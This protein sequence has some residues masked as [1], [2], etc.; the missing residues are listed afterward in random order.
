MAFS[1][2]RGA[3][4]ITRGA[5]LARGTSSAKHLILI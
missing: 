5:C 3:F 2:A 4:S 1:I